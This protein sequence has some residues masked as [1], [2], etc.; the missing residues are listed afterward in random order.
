[1]GCTNSV[2]EGIKDRIM[3]SAV[4]GEGTSLS[5]RATPEWEMMEVTDVTN[6]RNAEQ[7]SSSR[8]G[9][10][11]AYFTNMVVTTRSADLPR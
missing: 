7:G 5:K 6:L 3:V 4:V 9:D 2:Q 1:M 8:S 10:G 11:S